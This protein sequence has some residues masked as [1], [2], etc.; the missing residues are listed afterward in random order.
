[1]GYRESISFACGSREES[2]GWLRELRLVSVAP[3]LSAAF[4]GAIDAAGVALVIVGETCRYRI[5]LNG[6]ERPAQ[7]PFGEA[8]L[9]V[10]ASAVDKGQRRALLDALKQK[11]A[12]QIDSAFS[13]VLDIDAYL[14]EPEEVDLR[15]FVQEHAE[16]NQKKFRDALGQDQPRKGK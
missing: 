1:V 8:A 5:A 2:E 6:M 9:A 4:G 14:V 12:R 16:G 7:I 13:V 11:R 15:A 10:R 3:G